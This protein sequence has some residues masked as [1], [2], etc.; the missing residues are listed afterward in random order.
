[1]LRVN[2][3]SISEGLAVASM[4]IK[5]LASEYLRLMRFPKRVPRMG[6][7]TTP[8]EVLA[9]NPALTVLPSFLAASAAVN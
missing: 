7:L 5:P 4:V 3:P 1:V 6:K 2:L 8:E 9:A